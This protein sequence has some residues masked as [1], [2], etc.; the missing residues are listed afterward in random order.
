MSRAIIVPGVT[1]ANTSGVPSIDIAE[2]P[3]YDV[4]NM[5]GLAFWGRGDAVTANVGGGFVAQMSDR[6]T[7]STRLLRQPSGQTSVIAPSSTVGFLGNRPTL[8]W[9]AATDGRMDLNENI[10]PTSGPFAI[11]VAAHFLSTAHN[12]I[13]GNTGAS[14]LAANNVLGELRLAVASSGTGANVVTT[15]SGGSQNRDLLIGFQRR[16]D[17]ARSR[18]AIRYLVAGGSWVDVPAAAWCTADGTNTGA[19]RT[20]AATLSVGSYSVSAGYAFAGRL[21]QILVFNQDVVGAQRDKVEE[22]LRNYHRL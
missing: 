11:Y 6:R 17:G 14:Q 7:S 19:E 4:R 13:F 16:M 12:R 9:D 5:A 8:L 1:P 18:L 2:L 3:Y 22:Y 10:I 21:A 15:L 20:I